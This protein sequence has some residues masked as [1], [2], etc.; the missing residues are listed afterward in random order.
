MHQEPITVIIADD[1]ELLCEGFQSAFQ[2]EGINVVATAHNGE[3]LVQKVREHQPQVVVTD[4]RMPQLD[5]AQATA[6]IKKEFP[7][8]KVLALSAYNELG[9]IVE[10]KAAGADGFALKNTHNAE[11]LLG[12]QA[13]KE[14]R[15]FY[16]THT[17]KLM[18]DL[19]REPLPPVKQHHWRNSMTV[20]ENH[21][22]QVF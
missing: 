14:G 19:H 21:Y 13:L 5:G 22:R 18:L 2:K 10:M 8:I 3:E 11:L 1:H 7:G 20:F 16:C 17:A 6:I 15:E 9:L 12:L 4:I